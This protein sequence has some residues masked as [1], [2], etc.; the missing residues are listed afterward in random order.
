MPNAPCGIYHPG[1]VYT[2]LSKYTNPHVQVHT[3]TH[4]I[5]KNF[6]NKIYNGE[7]ISAKFSLSRGHN[8][9]E[10]DFMHV[11]MKKFP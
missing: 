9:T 1:K 10:H 5:P 7:T 6:A 11:Q 4:Q 8:F 3:T 2:F